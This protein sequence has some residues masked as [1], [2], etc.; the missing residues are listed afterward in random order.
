MS[1]FKRCFTKDEAEEIKPYLKY[2]GDDD[3]NR[4]DGLFQMMQMGE[5]FR[6]PVI[7]KIAKNYQIANPGKKLPDCLK[8]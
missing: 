1:G 3:F 4:I 7:T 6:T 2:Y 8:I 5:I